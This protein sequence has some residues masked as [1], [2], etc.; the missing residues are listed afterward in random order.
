M[1]L[2]NVMASSLDGRIGSQSLE[3]DWQRQQGRLSS[4]ADQKHLRNLIETADAII[5]GAS[6]I[7]A[8][9]E[10][11]DHPGV[12]GTP[13]K[14]YIL[15]KR[16]LPENCAFWQQTHI[17]RILVSP[18]PLPLVEGSG[19]ERLVFGQE[20][21]ASFIHRYIENQGGNRVLL[22]GGGLVN[23]WF[24]EAGLVDELKLTLSPLFIGRQ[25]APYL[26]QPELTRQMDFTLTGVEQSG[27]YLFLSYQVLPT[28]SQKVKR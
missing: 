5:V 27:D 23:H 1:E 9:G 28:L 3:G 17:P 22:F 25:E 10:C 15:G 13:P 21:P 26:I 19:V 8:N 24:Y 20:E 14:W 16:P 7:R 18:T 2:I 6:S 4:A 12:S 11:L